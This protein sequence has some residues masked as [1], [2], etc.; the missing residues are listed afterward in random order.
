[1]DLTHERIRQIIQEEVD[2]IHTSEEDTRRV[3]KKLQRIAKLS[4]DLHQLMEDADEHPAWL[5][6]NVDI[7]AAML[8]SIVDY[9]NGEDPR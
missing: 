8:Q 4:G 5:Y 2:H 3:K 9:K 6:E 7:V 1:M